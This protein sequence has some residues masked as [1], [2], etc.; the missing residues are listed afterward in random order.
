[1]IVN[2]SFHAH[3]IP[4]VASLALT[5]ASGNVNWDAGP[6]HGR[7]LHPQWDQAWQ[8]HS[9]TCLIFN[10][11]AT[12][13]IWRFLDWDSCISLYFYF[14]S[15]NI[16]SPTICELYWI[17]T[18][19]HLMIWS[20]L[21]TM[22]QACSATRTAHIHK[23]E[24]AMYIFLPVTCWCHRMQDPGNLETM[25][26]IDIV[27]LTQKSDSGSEERC[28]NAWWK[29]STGDAL[30]DGVH[31]DSPCSFDSSC[32]FG[33]TQPS[34]YSVSKLITIAMQDV[35]LFYLLRAIT[36]FPN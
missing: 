18:L 1:M 19:K 6:F 24:T 7:H 8:K 9:Q 27:C 22:Q 34:I 2:Q 12:L 36:N 10:F 15:S 21:L 3:R 4:Q 14:L 16:H 30:M 11:G 35:N 26:L 31:H 5:K 33:A 25:T 23:G 32:T 29:L 28:L 17:V 20:V 13:P